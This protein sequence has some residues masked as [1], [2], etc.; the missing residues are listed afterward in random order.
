M[1]GTLCAWEHAWGCT[2][3]FGAVTAAAWSLPTRCARCA[4]CPE[5]EQGGD[6]SGSEGEAVS[7]D[8]DKGLS[9][10]GGAASTGTGT[11]TKL[12]TAA[13]TK[14]SES[15][16]V[17]RRAE[18]ISWLRKTVRSSANMRLPR[19]ALGTATQDGDSTCF[20]IPTVTLKPKRFPQRD[21]LPASARE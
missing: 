6:T 17:T 19:T 3:R 10:D 14:S 4:G 5:P 9:S 20:C 18:Q 2:A 12:E 8:A 13:A 16:D 21:K 15:A 11:R 7:E 1:T